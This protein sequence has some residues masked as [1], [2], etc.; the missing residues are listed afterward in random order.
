MDRS[1]WEKIRAEKSKLRNEVIMLLQTK[2]ITYQ[3]S[4]D[5]LKSACSYLEQAALKNKI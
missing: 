2:K 1:E 4:L 5:V 3:E